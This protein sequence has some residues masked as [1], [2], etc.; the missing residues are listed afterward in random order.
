MRF[1]QIGTEIKNMG[2]KEKVKGLLQR[3]F[4]QNMLQ[5]RHYIVWTAEAAKNTEKELKRAVSP[6]HLLMGTGFKPGVVG[7]DCPSPYPVRPTEDCTFRGE[8]G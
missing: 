1:N 5:K 8:S 6:T 3:K 2:I 4:R 7:T